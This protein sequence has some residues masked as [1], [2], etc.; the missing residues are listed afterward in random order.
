M[1]SGFWRLKSN[2]LIDFRSCIPDELLAYFLSM[3]WLI[4]QLDFDLVRGHS[5]DW[6][7]ACLLRF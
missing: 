2:W 6:L 1:I 5:I 7:L 4:E 3:D